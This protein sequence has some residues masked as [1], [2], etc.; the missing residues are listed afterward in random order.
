MSSAR[1]ARPKPF[2][3]RVD[4]SAISADASTRARFAPRQK[5]IRPRRKHSAG[6]VSSQVES[7]GIGEM[8]LVPVEAEVAIDRSAVAAADEGLLLRDLWWL[9]LRALLARARG[10][11]VAYT[12]L[13]GDYRSMA[14]T[15]GY[16]G[17]IACAETLR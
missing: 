16:E 14:K 11:G 10:D 6:W 1:Q 13:R 17:H 7:V 15:L 4:T 2:F 12:R 5:C 8:G 3:I 9:R